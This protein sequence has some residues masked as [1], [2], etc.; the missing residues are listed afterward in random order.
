MNPT[1]E[2]MRKAK[3]FVEWLSVEVGINGPCS[4]EIEKM[5]E[6]KVLTDL[7]TT[8]AEE[9]VKE[10]TAELQADLLA[11]R[12]DASY[13]LRKRIVALEAE[14]LEARM[15]AYEDAAKEARAHG[16]GDGKSFYCSPNCLC[17][18]IE[19]AIRSKASGGK[20]KS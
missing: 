14:V 13:L 15:E 9:A 11:Q 12:E 20:E 16:V 4:Q 10:K 2:A 6:E 8:H 3:E 7:L 19:A 5:I 17:K 18:N 1:P